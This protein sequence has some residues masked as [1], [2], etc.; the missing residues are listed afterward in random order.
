MACSLV[1]KGHG[2]WCA[3][4]RVNFT[5]H[6]PET[7]ACDDKQTHQGFP[8]PCGENAQDTEYYICVA[9][10]TKLALEDG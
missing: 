10:Q 3:H 5:V 4:G 7:V 9:F 8:T 2:L 1:F 6:K